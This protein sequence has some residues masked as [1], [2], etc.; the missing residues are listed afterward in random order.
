MYLI[1]VPILWKITRPTLQCLPSQG[2][3]KPPLQALLS[4][5]WPEAMLCTTAPVT[6][7]AGTGPKLSGQAMS[8]SCS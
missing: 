8:S 5:L 1:F 7:R 4:G 2:G 3:E 6:S